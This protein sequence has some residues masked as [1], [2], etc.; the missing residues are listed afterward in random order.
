MR[1]TPPRVVCLP[2]HSTIIPVISS[3]I[4]SGHVKKVLSEYPDDELPLL[5]TNLKNALKMCNSVG[6]SPA[7]VPWALY[8][9]RYMFF[10][11][12]IDKCFFSFRW[13]NCELML[14]PLVIWPYVVHNVRSKHNWWQE[15]TYIYVT[16]HRINNAHNFVFLWWR[17][18]SYRITATSWRI[19]TKGS[20]SGKDCFRRYVILIIKIT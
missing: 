9:I 2:R 19:Y 8:Y 15:K 17:Y 14:S 16:A 18:H 5:V 6:A 7:Q 20:V 12:S 13:I 10:L 3:E 1:S 11:F 4:G